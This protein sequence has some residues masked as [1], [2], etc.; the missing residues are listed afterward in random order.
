MPKCDTGW[1][2]LRRNCDFSA[3]SRRLAWAAGR[4][5]GMGPPRPMPPSGTAPRPV[6]A[7]RATAL[8]FFANGAGFGVWA[9][10]IP[11]L[12]A[13]LGLSEAELGMAL[14]ALAAGAVAT[15][16]A[17]GRAI[18]RLGGVPTVA[19]LA[20]AFAGLLALPPLAPG[21]GW[22]MLACL[23]FGAANGGLDVAMNTHAAAVERAWRRPILSSF[24]A[25]Y[26]LGGLAGATAAGTM[27][28]AG[29]APAAG[30]GMGGVLLGAVVLAV[31]P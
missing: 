21:L 25:F 12:K 24:H 4:A 23:A 29:L 7:R 11:L 30:M 9:A 15:M 22:L 8:V 14:L 19:T 13:G 5:A 26:S 2:G 17:T 27:I 16:P 28:A 31:I 1:V 10:H 18:R 3:P 20:L 6:A